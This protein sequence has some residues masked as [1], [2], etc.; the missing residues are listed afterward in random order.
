MSNT[1]VIGIDI[2][3]SK[4]ECALVQVKKQLPPL[5]NQNHH[6]HSTPPSPSLV[7]NAPPPKENKATNI[8]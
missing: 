3:G 6:R 7:V 5:A 2:G 8:S 1:Y 4:I